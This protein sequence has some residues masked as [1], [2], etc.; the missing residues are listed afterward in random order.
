MIDT[1]FNEENIQQII[2]Q[3]KIEN[4]DIQKIK[5]L[6]EKSIIEKKQRELTIINVIS[7]MC[8]LLGFIAFIKMISGQFIANLQY[9]MIGFIFIYFGFSGI[10]Y[11][12]KAKSDLAL[13]KLQIRIREWI[14][15][16]ICFFEQGMFKESL[17][18]SDKCLNGLRPFSLLQTSKMP[19]L[20][21]TWYLKAIS[22]QKL[23]RHEEATE[24]FQQAQSCTLY[25]TTRHDW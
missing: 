8:L 3:S 15:N 4:N 19:E 16:G 11:Q 18:L 14:S 5:E 6:L 24:C 21:Q 25:Y 7:P 22:L 13:Q 9:G 2:I 10:L 1:K 23:G 17:D 12:R 20:T